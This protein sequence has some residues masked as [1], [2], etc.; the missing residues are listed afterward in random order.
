MGRCARISMQRH[1]M[2]VK[3]LVKNQCQVPPEVDTGPKGEEG[4]WERGPRSAG[5][6]GA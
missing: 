3:V 5:H 4:R 6:T 1:A 2:Q